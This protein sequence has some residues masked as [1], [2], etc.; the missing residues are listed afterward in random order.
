MQTPIRRVVLHHTAGPYPGLRQII[1][2]FE[3]T[4]VPLT[5]PVARWTPDER[6]ATA[7]MARTAPGWV[8][9]VEVVS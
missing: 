4:D 9:Y 8:E 5:L 7:S 1:G 3:G 6:P 2:T